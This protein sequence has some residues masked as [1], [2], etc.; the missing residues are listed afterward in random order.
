MNTDEETTMAIRFP[1]M[2]TYQLKA[3]KGYPRGIGLV[4]EEIV[5]TINGEEAA[6]Q[7]AL[8]LL[9]AGFEVS[10]RDTTEPHREVPDGTPDTPTQS[11]PA[12][13]A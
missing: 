12:E 2:T 4:Y 9:R 5:A 13:K 3:T 1:L 6:E 11:G 7:V 10:L 8:M